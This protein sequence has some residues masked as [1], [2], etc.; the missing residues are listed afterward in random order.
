[1]INQLKAANPRVVENF[2]LPSEPEED[3]SGLA[4]VDFSPPPKPES[5]GVER[6]KDKEKA[7]SRQEQ[8]PAEPY[9]MMASER[10]RRTSFTRNLSSIC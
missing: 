8:H 9:S 10:T 3:E 1:M 6:T 4:N 5:S 7:L 2:E